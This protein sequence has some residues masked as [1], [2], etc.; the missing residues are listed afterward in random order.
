MKR[1][2]NKMDDLERS[3]SDMMNDAGLAEKAATTTTTR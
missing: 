3:I 2:G 1:M